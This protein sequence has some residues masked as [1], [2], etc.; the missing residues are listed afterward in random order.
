MTRTVANPP[1]PAALGLRERKKQKT[2]NAIQ[3]EAMRLFAK[4]G[5]A[6]TTIE[7]IAEAVEISP[8]TFFNYFPSKEELI[9]FDDYDPLLAAAF[10]A[11][12]KDEPLGI[13]LRRA[14]VDQ[15]STILKRDRDLVLARAKLALRVPELRA[16]FWEETQK[17]QD[18][19]QKLIAQRRGK[20]PDAYE[21]R[22]AASI[23]VSAMFVAVLEWV[24]TEGRD[25]LAR[26]VNR[27]LNVVEA[28]A[29][30]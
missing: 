22:V 6:E 12:P 3:R 24:S 25:D 9:A 30:L 29:G 14:I 13:A 27:A 18:F 26:L 15:L 4:Q 1:G 8:S 16:R 11:R 10:A 23:I 5:Y 2:R 20:D 7:Q 19:V 21:V 28:G 17:S